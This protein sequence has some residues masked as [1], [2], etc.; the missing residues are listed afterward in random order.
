M[1]QYAISVLVYG[2]GGWI[3]Y[4]EEQFADE[5][6]RYLDRGFRAV[7]IKIRGPSEDWDVARVKDARNLIGSEVGLMVDANQGLTLE[8]ALRTARRLE[9]CN[10]QWIEE[11][12]RKDDIES[13]SRL[14]SATEIP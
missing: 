5:L 4:S 12:F 10:L 14:A 8:R 7:K 6:R 13:Y 3:S 11:P 2:S 1:G 9:A